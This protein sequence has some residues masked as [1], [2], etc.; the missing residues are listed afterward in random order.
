MVLPRL[1]LW[2]HVPRL[3]PPKLI[4]FSLLLPDLTPN[5]GLWW[6]FFIEIFDS[7]R[8]FF[9]V[10]FQLHLLIYVAPLCIRLHRRPLSIITT[11]VGII[12]ISKSYP[13]VS[14]LSLYLALLSLETD[15]F[16]RTPPPKQPLPPPTTV[17]NV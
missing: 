2:R 3:I 17:L 10:V 16:P 15:I 8:S 1:N 4:R 5:V 14:D 6:Y 13:S 9:L 11:L 12:S 7:F